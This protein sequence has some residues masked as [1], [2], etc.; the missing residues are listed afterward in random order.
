MMRLLFALAYI[1]FGIW[2]YL[3]LGGDNLHPYIG[4]AVGFGF[5]LSSVIVC[6]EGFI[7]KLRG[8]SDEQHA[9]NLI[10]ND[11]AVIEKYTVEQSI[12]FEDLGTGCTAYLLDVGNNNIVCLYSQDYGFE[13]IYEQPEINQERMFPTEKFSLIRELK[14][15][16][17]LDVTPEGRVV[18]TIIVQ[19]PNIEKLFDFGFELED[20]EIVKNVKFGEDLNALKQ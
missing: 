11:K 10:S 8:I 9:E 14:K 12:V 2:V 13:P 17:I 4:M 19:T 3:W 7:R 18:E 6:N 16:R 20:G 1:W 15:Q 5:L